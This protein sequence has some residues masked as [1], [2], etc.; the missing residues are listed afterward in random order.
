M[1]IMLCLFDFVS[2][3]GDDLEIKM[4][5][6]LLN[7]IGPNSRNFSLSLW[8]RDGN[9]EA[10]DTVL[11]KLQKLREENN[12]I[13]LL[14]PELT[15]S[16]E[17]YSTAAWLNNADRIQKLEQT[18]QLAEKYIN[19]IDSAKIDSFTANLY[20]EWAQL[21]IRVSKS[22]ESYSK[23]G[24][25]MDVSKRMKL[26]INRYP[27]NGFAYSAYLWAGLYYSDSILDD[28]EK[29]EV[30]QDL[31]EKRDVVENEIIDNGFDANTSGELDARMDKLELTDERFNASIAKGKAY[32]I[33]FRIREIRGN[34][35]DKL[36]FNLPLTSKAAPRKK[37]QKIVDIL[38][39]EDFQ[40]IVTADPACMYMLIN[41]KWLLLTRKPIKPDEENECIGLST[42]VWKKFYSFCS[43]YLEEL[44]SFRPP[45]II[46]LLALCAAHIPEYRNQCSTLFEE[47]RHASTF[48]KKSL[49]IICQ[50]NGTPVFFGGRLN[51]EY[52][53]N[54]N[55]GYIQINENGFNEAIYFRAEKIGVNANLLRENM[56]LNDL[57]IATSYSGFQI[58][59][60]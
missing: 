9:N 27:R 42:D 20:V 13:D 53:I 16:R 47:L 22:D 5:Q 52:N 37:C 43:K 17:I 57:V 12:N 59:K 44:S 56:P 32:G 18:K 48:E 54:K 6:N 19:E 23:H 26:V 10:F 50:E 30:L 40:H 11:A 49:H 41:A 51:G 46:Y 45:R 35:E 36:D 55:R 28:D 7:R 4:M 58:C 34:G 8:N 29:M 1:D 14:I 38:E 24:M 15:L 3:S 2:L 31:S 33:Y 60:L 39:N 21:C 25:F